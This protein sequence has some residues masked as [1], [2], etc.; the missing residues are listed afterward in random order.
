MKSKLW[1]VSL[2]RRDPVAW[3]L[4]FDFF[5]A[6]HD[7]GSGDPRLPASACTRRRE[8]IFNNQSTNC[9]KWSTQYGCSFVE[10]YEERLLLGCACTDAAND[11][12]ERAGVE[13]RFGTL[14]IEAHFSSK[15]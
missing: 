13:C 2:H 1:P 5:P 9:R 15:D 11:V 7:P 10:L 3:G 14:I 4:L 12:S 8:L 6:L